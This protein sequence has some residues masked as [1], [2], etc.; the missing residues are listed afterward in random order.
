[1]QHT[2]MFKQISYVAS[3]FRCQISYIIAPV[4][5]LTLHVFQEKL[6]TVYDELCGDINSG[7]AYNVLNE[8]PIIQDCLS[9]FSR[10][11]QVV[12]EHL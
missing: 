5:D 9:K 10:F 12:S 8:H 3:V 6:Q 1:M 7:I 4:G 11:K 2:E